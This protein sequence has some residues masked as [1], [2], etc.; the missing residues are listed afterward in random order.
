MKDS[1]TQFFPQ[2]HPAVLA[3]YLF[4]AVF[5]TMFAMNPEYVV[6]SFLCAGIYSVTLMGVQKYLRTLRLISAMFLITAIFN[7]L[8]TRVSG[9][10]LLRIGNFRLTLESLMF[11]VCMGGMLAA[12]IVWLT[13]LNNLI[14]GDKLIFLLGKSA[15]TTAMVISM[16]LKLVP[17]TTRK[18]REIS[19]AQ[20]VL[21]P[22]EPSANDRI[23]NGS[24]GRSA[25][26]KK[27]TTIRRTSKI[28]GALM[29]RAME[30]GIETAD[31]MR[32][33]G[34]GVG[35]RT[36]YKQRNLRS[37]DI[38]SLLALSVL[39]LGNFSW[40]I[41]GNKTEV[42]S[43]IIDTSLP[44]L[45]MGLAYVIMLLYPLLIEGVARRP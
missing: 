41:Y 11:V 19:D 17:E 8:T 6:L 44:G 4:G 37:R 32:A 45:L 40:I 16:I 1:K 39:F 14:S 13:C 5:C 36:R 21:H 27:V 18:Y 34:Y 30:D 38:F 10:V 20:R 26:K 3:V 43:K 33:R 9:E 23:H 42:S 31:A 35:L 7:L 22:A 28:C 24:L 15:P 12:A 2:Y 25:F 29:S